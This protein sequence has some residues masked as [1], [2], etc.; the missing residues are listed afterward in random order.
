[1]NAEVFGELRMKRSAKSAVLSHG[2]DLSVQ[3][4]KDFDAGA[5]VDDDGGADKNRGQR[6]FQTGYIQFR[7]ETVNLS[8]ERIAFHL[9]VEDIERELVRSASNRTGH[10][11]HPHARSPY[12][13]P[14]G[15][16]LFQGF[17]KAIA[18]HQ[19]PDRCA[20]SAR[21]DDPVDSRKVIGRA[22]LDP[23]FVGQPAAPQRFEMFLKVPLNGDYANPFAHGLGVYPANR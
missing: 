1:M 5:S 8:A 22:N 3:L 6:T 21:K 17:A 15:R 9:D 18:L 4:G 13:H 23:A 2:D 20:L 14:V 19:K 10:E 11:D 12:R 16:R 7:L